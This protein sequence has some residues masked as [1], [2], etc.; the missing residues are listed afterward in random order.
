[1]ATVLQTISNAKIK[2]RYKEV[3]ASEGINKKL[4]VVLPAGPYRGLGLGASGLA[5]NVTIE[6][7]PVAL[8]H[9][10]DRKSVV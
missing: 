5:M 4:A 3:Y 9:V 8:D 1:M 7:D 10:A 2:V 6:A